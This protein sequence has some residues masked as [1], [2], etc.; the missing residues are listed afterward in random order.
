MPTTH[1]PLARMS[2]ADDAPSARETDSIKVSN[3]IHSSSSDSIL[4]CR[5]NRSSNGSENSLDPINVFSNGPDMDSKCSTLSTFINIIC[6]AIGVGS[7]QLAYTLKQSGWFGIIFIVFAAGLAFI[8]S[9]ITIKCI[10]L[11]PGGGRMAGFHDIG[12]EAFGKYG[13]Y[14]ITVFNMVNIIGSVGIYA[15]LSAN[16]ISD[17]FLQVGV[18]ISSRVLMIVTTAIMCA[19]TLFAKTLGETL[20]V[21]LIGTGTSIIVT[22]IV[23]AMACLYPIKNGEMHV[24]SIVV[25]KGPVSHHGVIPGGFALA[26][27]SASFAYIGTTI[28]PHLEGGMK[29]PERFYN[30]F[31]GAL[32][33]VAGI[34]VIMAATGYWAYGD[35]TLS[36]ITL[37]FPKIWP[38]I[39]ATISITIHVLFAG[40]L[41][42]V[43]MALEIENGLGISKKDKRKER[44]WRLC[45]RVLSALLILAISEALPFFDDVISLV[46]ALTNP[47]L[48][49]LAPIACYVKLKGWK[50]CSWTLLMALG[51]L[52]LFGLFVSIV[53]LVETI[54]DILLAYKHAK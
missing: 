53:G 34:Y 6:L 41:F 45:T 10:Y 23:I 35:Q 22:I 16:N 21:S 27:T 1:I 39:M 4:L 14:T 52:L 20:L 24:G 28:A 46:S 42:L 40:P 7:L 26:I 50:S 13:Y 54:K 37:N 11:K 17:L 31:G 30:V 51:I 33:A 32:A 47:V 36:P 3:E 48:V 18:H 2:Y 9:V 8:T 38:T 15:I 49:Y 29:R 19:P 12:Y 25:H 43:Q 44:I 5:L